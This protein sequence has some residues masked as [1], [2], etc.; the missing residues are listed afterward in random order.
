M[1]KTK[2]IEILDADKAVVTEIETPNPAWS[3]E[4]YCRNRVTIGWSW[5]EKELA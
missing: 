2:T 1:A 5:R 3:F 4:Q